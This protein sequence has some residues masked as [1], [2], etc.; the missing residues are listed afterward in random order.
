MAYL[1]TD[2]AAGGQAALQLQQTM[3]AAPNVQQVEANKMQEAQVKLQQDQENLSKTKLA[4]IVSETGIK[5]E[6][7]KQDIVANWMKDPANANKSAGD[8]A[9]G[10]SAAFMGAGLVEDGE[11]LSTAAANA[12]YKQALVKS[13]EAAQQMQVVGSAYSTI[14]DASPEEFKTLLG[15]MS[16]EQKDAITKSIPKF[17]EENNPKL[18][19]SQLEHLM[20]TSSQQ[21]MQQKLINDA[22]I[23]ADRNATM[24]KAAEIRVAGMIAAKAMG[25]SGNKE[26]MAALKGYDTAERIID[27]RYKPQL[28][29]A[30]ANLAALEE[31]V[32]VSKAKS[33]FGTPD[34]TI[35]AKLDAASK[36]VKEL[37]DK[38][39]ADKIKS[40]K[41]LPPSRERTS[42]LS[43]LTSVESPLEEEA[44]ADKP[45]ADKA[46]PGAAPSPT[47]GG[48]PTPAVTGGSLDQQAMAWAK[49]NPTDPRSKAILEKAQAKA[50]PSA[51]AAV[52][53]P[54]P[55][56]SA[57]TV[58]SELKEL[59][60]TM[61]DKAAAFKGS[62]TEYLKD[63]A[64]A[65]YEKKRKKAIEEI[66]KKYLD[67]KSA[68]AR[69]LVYGR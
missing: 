20:M 22:Q 29:K 31:Q 58:E 13:K 52:A 57:P 1:M 39:L 63:P 60:K 53:T 2:V 4:N 50:A 55:T 24:I 5:S 40:A 51:P 65:E 48:K 67:P 21:I 47:V 33:W 9:S 11:K 66:E 8:M 16:K 32:A 44:P 43:L 17:F 61:P 34:K 10:L 7:K 35:V 26:D 28:T 64:N 15:Q 3:A 18:Q 46:K 56:S 38:I 14:A 37:D 54:T 6:S 59:D 12:E 30:E 25:G 19:K 36:A 45:D 42:I 69:K 23:H 62:M 41:M 27:S 49:A 68:A